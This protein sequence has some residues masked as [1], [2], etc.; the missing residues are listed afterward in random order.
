MF[1]KS[2]VFALFLA[3]FSFAQHAPTA[4]RIDSLLTDYQQSESFNGNVLIVRNGKT[5]LDKSYGFADLDSKREL[6]P[7]SVFEL[8]SVSKQFTAMGI[9]LSRKRNTL[10][11]SDTITKFLPELSDYPKITIDQLVHHTSGLPDYMVLFEEHWDKSKIAVNQDIVDL[12]AEHEPEMEFEPGS[13]WE[14]SNT[15]YAL[16]GLIIEKANGISYGDFLKKNIFEPL[17]MNNTRVY[18]S[19]Y[20]PEKIENYAKGYIMGPTGTKILPDSLGNSYLSYYLDG[21]VGDGMV[22]ST[23]GDLLKWDQALRG[24]QVLSKADK[25]LFYKGFTLNDGKVTN[26]G[27]GIFAEQTEKYGL[28][29]NHSG[30][31]AGYATFFEQH[32]D[33]DH[34]FIL[35]QNVSTPLTKTPAR[36]IRKILYGEKLEVPKKELTYTRE[37]LKKYEGLYKSPEF[38][39]DIRIFVEDD[40]LKAQA[41]GQGSLI[42]SSYEKDRFVFKMAGIDL[43]F[44]TANNKMEL[45]QAG[46]FV[47]MYRDK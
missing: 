24:D 23:T 21:I 14:Y 30:G 31:W 27:F 20:A 46:N 7:N 22:N 41:T 19:R 39:L 11:L 12:L 32:L 17:Q 44:D 26:Y 40:Q 25:D 28:V 47:E 4:Q 8:A 16:L 1:L 33:N 42:L 18:R 2:L 13:Q 15:G 6:N 29:A 9:L 38:P 36:S 3:Q 37:E 35:L 43:K 5:I 34:T 45:R 10:K